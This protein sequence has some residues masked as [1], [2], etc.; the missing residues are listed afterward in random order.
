MHHYEIHGKDSKGYEFVYSLCPN[1]ETDAYSF[2]DFWQP[3]GKLFKN[4]LESPCVFLNEE[5]AKTSMY[6]LSKEFSEMILNIV[7]VED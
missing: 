6:N 3:F 5:S 1:P 2:D 4:V 7:K